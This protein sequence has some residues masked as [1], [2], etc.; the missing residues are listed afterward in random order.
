[1]IKAHRISTKYRICYAN[2]YIITTDTQRREVDT[3]PF[4][5]QF[6]QISQAPEALG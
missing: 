3:S 4:K 1:M 2:Q 5:T 6:V